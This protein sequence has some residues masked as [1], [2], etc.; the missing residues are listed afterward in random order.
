MFPIG[1][2]IDEQTVYQRL[3]SPRY[4]R[5][6]AAQVPRV[7]QGIEAGQGSDIQRDPHLRP[8]PCAASVLY[9]RCRRRYWRICL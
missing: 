6:W 8:I 1:H 3:L 7:P 4:H 5:Q 9:A 2:A